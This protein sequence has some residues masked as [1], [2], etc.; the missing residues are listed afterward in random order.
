M[1]KKRSKTLA[2]W[3]TELPGI[4][5]IPF[6]VDRRGLYRISDVYKGYDPRRPESWTEAFDHRV[7]AW[8]VIDA[9]VPKPK[10]RRLK[11]H[12]A[13]AERL[14]DT[15]IGFAIDRFLSAST[16]QSKKPVVGFMGGHD[17]PRDQP[18]FRQVALIAR[19]LR[20]LNF[21]IV[22]GGGPGLMEAANFGAFMAP[23]SPQQFDDAL[24][25]LAKFP[26]TLKH[27]EWV[28]SAAAV[29]ASLLKRWNAKEQPKSESLGI[30]TWYYG[31]EPPN[32]FASH[33]GKY[34]FNS[35]R[36]DG[37][38]SI[39][40]GGI[41]FGP[42]NAGTVQEV[43]QDAPLN[44]YRDL[45]TRPTP[46]ILLGVQYWNPGMCKDSQLVPLAPGDTRKPVWPL[47][48]T[49]STQAD[50]N[51]F[52]DALKLTDNPKEVVDFITEFHARTVTQSASW[53][54]RSERFKG[55]AAAVL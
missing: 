1:K 31:N 28:A 36:E 32:L 55:R 40:G 25:T 53:A 51:H 39:A 49:L 27:A 43:F 29:R 35:V 13:I 46:M 19:S 17:T 34:F 21:T 47:L 5:D 23:Y 7:Y 50:K 24:A 8:T 33:T 48:L 3:L 52:E 44:Y 14:H 9:T 22:S 37:L 41:V 10:L 30:P 20:L 38:V 11:A 2:H 15:A 6:S 45:G 12:E 16:D 4:E 18:E 42:G 26:D 54:D